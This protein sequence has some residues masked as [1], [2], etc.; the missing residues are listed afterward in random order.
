MYSLCKEIGDMKN[1]TLAIA[2]L[3][4]SITAFVLVEQRAKR[5]FEKYGE[6]KEI[7]GEVKK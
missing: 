7:I 3:I 6:K 5:L 4:A 1:K 2:I